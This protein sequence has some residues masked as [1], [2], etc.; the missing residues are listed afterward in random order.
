MKSRAYIPMS[1]AEA[2]T[3]LSRQRIDQ[4]AQAGR[5]RRRQDPHRLRWL[6]SAGDLRKHTESAK[7]GRPRKGK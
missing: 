5:V 6:Y 7:P 4:L 3:G 2:L 1:E